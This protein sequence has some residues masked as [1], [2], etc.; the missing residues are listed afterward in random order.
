MSYQ[1]PPS[2]PIA[3]DFNRDKETHFKGG[4][5]I[6]KKLEFDSTNYGIKNIITNQDN[7]NNINNNNNSGSIHYPTPLPSSSIGDLPSSPIKNTVHIHTSSTSS[8]SPSPLKSSNGTNVQ[9]PFVVH[10]KSIN[11]KLV[12][13]IQLHPNEPATYKF[14]RQSSNCDVVLPKFK[15][16]SRKHAILSYFPT[17]NQLKLTCLGLNGLIVALPR[18][19]SCHLMRRRDNQFEFSSNDNL[20]IVDKEKQLLKEQNLTSFALRKGDT[21]V[22]PFMNNT[23]IDF[24]NVEVLLTMKQLS[25]HDHVLHERETSV[26]Q[27]DSVVL[28]PLAPANIVSDNISSAPMKSSKR[29]IPFLES[30]HQDKRGKIHV[31]RL[32]KPTEPKRSTEEI[33]D[34]LTKRGIDC[35]D[36]Q[37]IL[38]NYLAFANVQQ[39][40]LSLLREANSQVKVLKKEEVRAL[41]ANEPCIGVIYRK[42]KDAA[43]KPLEEEYYYDLENDPNQVRKFN[44]LSIKGGRTGLRSCRKTHKQYFWKKPAK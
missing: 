28:K 20:E 1:F 44:V 35:Q 2:S 13:P 9:S 37:H 41:L 31:R 24:R 27:T 42:G 19:I 3:G 7:N 12:I 6:P 4:D 29:L 30:S 17:K 10:D 15:L 43:G 26:G 22:L 33:I 18:H 5:S 8:L 14:G 39:T 38:A 34:S 11:N 36:L 21:V 32:T 23:I 16:I 25:F 40:P